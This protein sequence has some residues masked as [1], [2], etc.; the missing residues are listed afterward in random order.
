MSAVA[1]LLGVLAVALAWPV[2]VVLSRAAWPARA[3]GL[4]LALW[5][6]VALGGALSM[7]GCLVVIGTVPDGSITGAA[8]AL[9]PHLVTGPL[10]PEFSVID[11][12]A[13]TLA[14]GLAVHLLLNVAATAVRAERER[15]RQHQLIQMLSDPMPG[16]PG[17]RVLAHPVPLAYCVPGLRTATVLTEGLVAALTPDELRAVVVHERTHLDQFHHLVLLSFRAWHAALPWFPIANRAERSVTVLTEMLADDGARRATG[18]VPLAGALTR[19]GS[20]AEPGA[21]ADT[22]GIAP[23]RAMLVDRLTRLESTIRPLGGWTRAAIVAAAVLLI[24]VPLGSMLTI[25]R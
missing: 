19:L 21:Y 25:L 24:A 10:P 4:A 20:S 3:P 7:I 15:R 5:Q 11:L 13:L 9:L 14:A 12:A 23:D 8:T 16:E 2:P 22:G 1:A 6:A 18:A 17:T